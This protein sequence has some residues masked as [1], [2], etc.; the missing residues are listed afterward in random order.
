VWCPPKCR[1]PLGRCF[2]LSHFSGPCFSES[3]LG[4]PPALPAPANLLTFQ[5]DARELH[6]TH[7]I[8]HADLDRENVDR[9]R[10]SGCT[11]QVRCAAFVPSF[12]W[13]FVRLLGQRESAGC[14]FKSRHG[15]RLPAL[16]SQERRRGRGRAS[17]GVRQSGTVQL[18]RTGRARL[19]D[20]TTAAI[21]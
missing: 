12:W 3:T 13:M 6:T 8:T 10:E 2:C 21:T 1:I 16:L 14:D 18:V 20:L 4:E 11:A 9:G 7:P 15:R 17:K 19:V 5:I